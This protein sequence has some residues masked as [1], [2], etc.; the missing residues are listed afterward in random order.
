L[1]QNQPVVRLR[2]LLVEEEEE[3]EEEKEALLEHLSSSLFEK[4]R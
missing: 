3:K 1:E 4:K 2:L